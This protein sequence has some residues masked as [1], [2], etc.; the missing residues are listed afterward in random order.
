MKKSFV[1]ILVSFL[2]VFSIFF[3][4]M[5]QFQSVFQNQDEKTVSVLIDPGHGGVDGGAVGVAGTVEKDINLDIAKRLSDLF[6]LFGISCK[7]TREEDVSLGAGAGNIRAQKN[8]D[9]KAR[10]DMANAMNDACLL[11]IHLNAFSDSSCHGAQVFFAPYGSSALLARSI[12]TTLREGLDTKNHRVAKPAEH[13][14]YLLRH[15]NILSI[16]I[17]CGFLSN[18]NEEKNLTDFEYQKR[19]AACIVQGYQ[20]YRK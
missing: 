11:S 5:M 12:Q 17:E 8:A 20:N 15:I 6:G 1:L 10:V 18:R 9:L 16:I 4:P 14:H 7:L 19:L 13:G 2:L 3:E